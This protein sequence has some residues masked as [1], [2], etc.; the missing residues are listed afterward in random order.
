MKVLNNRYPKKEPSEYQKKW[1]KSCES[2]G[3]KFVKKGTPEYD[4]VLA[5]FRKM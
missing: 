3:Y 5:H 1:I 4:L 2:L